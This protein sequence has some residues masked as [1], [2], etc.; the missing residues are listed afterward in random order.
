MPAPSMGT[1]FGRLVVISEPFGRYKVTCRCDCGVEKAIRY[2]HLSS[3]AG[4]GKA[5]SCGCLNREKTSEANTTHGKLRGYQRPPEYAIW[6]QMINR[7]HRQPGTKYAKNHGDRGIEVCTRWRWSFENFLADMG[8]RPGGKREYTIER[9]KNE[10]NYEPGNCRWATYQEQANNTRTNRLLT[11]DGRT[12]T[13]AEWARERKINPGTLISRL[14]RSLW[15]TRRAL[16]FD[17]D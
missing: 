2:D 12:M 14:D 3:E 4:S 7:C 17:L 15:S 6:Q 1:R 10:R 5:A 9:I 11:Y 8:P 16:G 13:L